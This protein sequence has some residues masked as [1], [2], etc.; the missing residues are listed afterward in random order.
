MSLKA[1]W[2]RD[3]LRKRVKSGFVGY[4]VATIAY[5]GSNDQTATKV[6]VGIIAAE[7]GEAD[8][9]ERWYSESEDVRVSPQV[10]K[11]VLD[12]IS[13]HNVKSVV[14]ADGILGCPHEEGKD[15]PDG[16]SC[17]ACPFWKNRDRFTGSVIH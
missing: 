11:E 10:L 12:F 17:P 9:L 16:E 15:Y 5:Y 2:Y 3:R 7:G 1:T 14:V 4:P 13:R 6:A 8:V